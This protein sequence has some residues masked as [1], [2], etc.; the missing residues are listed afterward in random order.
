MISG[1][2]DAP[3]VKR[4]F[5]DYVIHLVT[6]LITM[7]KQKEC[8]KGKITHAVQTRMHLN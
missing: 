4:E 6:Y 2:N 8:R 1:S 3:Y 7:D 5:L